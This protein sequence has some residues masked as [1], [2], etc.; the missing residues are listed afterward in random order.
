LIPKDVCGKLSI[1]EQT[2]GKID[3]IE[4]RLNKFDQKFGTVDSEIKSC[5]ERIHVL[6]HGVQFLSDNKDEHNSIKIK[7]EA[8]SESVEA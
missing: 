8:I 6:E 1:I 3:S 5:Q 4:D 2:L 7:L